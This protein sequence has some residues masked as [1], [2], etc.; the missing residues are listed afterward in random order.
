MGRGQQGLAAGAFVAAAVFSGGCTDRHDDVTAPAAGAAARAGGDSVVAG[1][2]LVMFRGTAGPAGTTSL[3]L[4]RGVD[5]AGVRVRTRVAAAGGQVVRTHDGVVDAI[6]VRLSAAA[7]ATL[8][9]DPAVAVVEP[10]PV[11]WLSGT[12]TNA[13]WDLDRLD[14]SALPLNGS[15]TYGG[16]GSGVSIYMLDTGINITH[17]DFGGRALVG[18]DFVTPGGNAGDCVGHGTSTASLAG[19]T[20][21]GV[22]KR[23]TL[24][25]VRV[26]DCSFHSPGSDM[27]DGINWVA[28][29][30]QKNPSRPMVAN[31]S[32]NGSG[33]ATLDSAVAR[34]VAAGVTLTVSAGNGGGNACVLWPSRVPTVVAVG[35][36]DASDTF[37]SSSNSGSCLALLAPAVNVGVDAGTSSQNFG[38]TG[39]SASAPI[40]AG[41]AAVYLSAHPTATPAQVK[42]ALVGGAVSGAVRSVPSGTPNRLAN[43]TQLAGVTATGAAT[44]V[45]RFTWNCAGL[46]PH[47]CAF[48]ASGSTSGVAITS[49]AWNWGNGRAETHTVPT[50]KNTWA[51]TGTYNVTLTVTDANGRTAAA[52]HAVPIP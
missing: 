19:S 17:P 21:Y 52:T 36:T 32:A 42:A 38:F 28:S 33:S 43:V 16:D 13:P 48:D 1:Q 50:V 31:I 14:Q 45:A 20:T 26:F 44:P 30:K 51:A 25:A 18:Y 40:A 4:S 34:L 22:A 46:N 35:G 37:W 27:V 29:Q 9:D 12:Q 3:H 39:T 11:L 10:D 6:T 41:L 5:D 8:R 15:Y 47:Q 23:A 2:Y 24:Y 7:A 49:Y